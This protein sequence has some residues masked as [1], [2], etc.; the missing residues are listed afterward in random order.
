VVGSKGKVKSD[1]EQNLIE[2]MVLEI[3]EEEKSI[4][5]DK[6]KKDVLKRNTNNNSIQENKNV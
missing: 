5:E 3:D 4:K 2:K 1:I 6:T